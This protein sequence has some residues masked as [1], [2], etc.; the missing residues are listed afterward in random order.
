MVFLKNNERISTKQLL[1]S[2][3][4]YVGWFIRAKFCYACMTLEYYTLK[5]EDFSTIY[6]PA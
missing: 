5:K 3:P 6:Q 1:Q 2:A 4:K